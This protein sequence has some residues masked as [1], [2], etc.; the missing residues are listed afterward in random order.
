MVERTESKAPSVAPRSEVKA[1]GDESRPHEKPELVVESREHT[2]A[3]LGV[4]RTAAD[5]LLTSE[6]DAADKALRKLRTSADTVIADVRERDEALLARRPE[7]PD[8]LV[9]VLKSE[10]HTEDQVRDAERNFLDRERMQA[11]DERAKEEST[12]T[13]KRKVTDENLSRERA[14]EDLLLK[15]SEE[16]FGLLVSQVK[17]F[18]IFLL[19]PRGIIISWNEG[20]ERIKGY[21]EAEVIGKPF[22]I[23]YTQHDLDLGLP[24]EELRIATREGRVESEGL[25][26]RKDG[27]TFMANVLITALYGPGAVHLGFAKITRD[28]T[29]RFLRTERDLRRTEEA[30]K[31]AN[32][33]VAAVV[34][35]HVNAEKSMSAHQRL[36]ER[37]TAQIAKPRTA[38]A[39]I[40]VASLWMLANVV[41]PHLG[42]APWDPLPF[43]WLQGAVG[44]YASLVTT[45]VLATQNRQQAKAEQQ[46]YLELQV[47]LAAEKKTAKVI[48]LLEELRRDMPS[49]PSRVDHQAAAMACAVD[50][51]A[52]MHAFKET[53]HVAAPKA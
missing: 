23:F 13:E 53:L 27:S 21:R 52:L 36:V 2:D 38:I 33:H 47:N 35:I 16:P 44:A 22:S 31:F 20:A 18:A 19:D 1:H 4:E 32:D 10:R 30:L 28:I 15:L 46:A 51:Q 24:E 9:R 17:D 11:V 42:R 41:A 29:E 48:E 37:V 49:V 40:T 25:R 39:L 14:A 12:T 3:S 34:A 50:P 7:D 26:V 5:E 43:F 6:H 8:E 45:I